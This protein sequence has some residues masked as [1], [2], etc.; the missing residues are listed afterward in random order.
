MTYQGKR[1][2]ITGA[3]SGIGRALA[4]ELAARGAKVMVADIAE[5]PLRALARQLGDAA[6][7]RVCDVADHQAV[8]ALGEAAVAAWGGC[9]FAFA[10]AGVLTNGR[11]SRATPAQVDWLMGINLR[12]VW[13]TAAVFTDIMGAQ[14]DGGHIIL[15][16]SE[17]SLGLQHAG[18]AIYTASKHAVL[19]L[20]EV[21]RAELP[22]Q[23]KV[24]VLCPGVVDT[25]LG[26]GPVPD[27]KVRPGQ[28]GMNA[29]I[30]AEGKSAQE[31]AAHTLDHV[32]RGAFYIVTHPH[33]LR[34]AQRRLAEI[35]Q[36]YA[37]QAPWFDG[38]ER[39][40][41]NV[42]VPRLLARAGEAAK[43]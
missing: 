25:G 19:G 1:A 17:H 27:A 3:A 30:L 33:S 37:E 6:Q 36:A 12:G 23:V 8:M 40:D 32:A 14:P 35:E 5:E 26:S 11:F 13:S 18:A 10:N 16:G 9:D 41:I 34:A 20:A 15:T 42:L 28:E 24:S 21:M 4:V 38:A 22:A 7:W 29:R 39:Y 43:P 2:V 31:I